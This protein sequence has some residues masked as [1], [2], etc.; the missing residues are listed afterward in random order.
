[1]FL[2]KILFILGSVYPLDDANSNIIN[3]IAANLNARYE[4]IEIYELGLNNQPITISETTVNGVTVYGMGDPFKTRLS[5]KCTSYLDLI[6][7]RSK[8]RRAALLIKRP[9][10]AIEY[11]VKRFLYGNIQ[12]CYKMQIKEIINKDSI[13]LIVSVSY[14]FLSAM[15]AA[16][17][18][19]RLPF[20]Y[21]QLD[22]YFSHYLQRNR[23]K[24]L[25]QERYVCKRADAILMTNLIYDEYMQT[26]LNVYLDKTSVLEFPVIERNSEYVKIPSSNE[27]G[28]IKLA[29][30]GTLYD[31]IR[32][33]LYLF[34]ILKELVRRG[35]QIHLDL[36]GPIVGDI[37]IPHTEWLTYHGRLS[38][39]EANVFIQKA[40]ILVNIGNSIR[41]QMPSKIFEYFNTGKPIINFYKIDN[42]PTLPYVNR[43][44]YC[45]SV[46]ESKYVDEEIYEQ[47]EAFIN[48]N[49]DNMI[50]SHKV[51][52]IFPECTIDKVTDDFLKA[53]QNAINENREGTG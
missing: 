29:Y 27:E 41:N 40:D 50:P 5:K 42:C 35:N 9:K 44:P 39:T 16:K 24:A 15:S 17:L 23:R 6:S 33:P 36:V 38:V 19:T 14:P 18:K 30:I 1:M 25:K 3:R 31:D 49:K 7:V 34:C 20:I 21:Y 11:I 28:I 43:Y 51:M 47:I 45:I 13:D 22:P 37:E 4:G 10:F 26:S 12:R 48:N 32:S 2:L 8:K 53:V 52:D 46:D